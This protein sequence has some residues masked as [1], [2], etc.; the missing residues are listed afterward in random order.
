MARLFASL[1]AIW[2]SALLVA[3]A[4]AQ[5]KAAI[6]NVKQLPTE[7]GNA[8]Y[9]GNREPLAP[10]P[11]VKLPIGA[12]KPGGWLLHQ[13]ELMA[14]GMTGR[15]HEVSPFLRDDNGWVSLKGR[16]WE[17]PPYWLKGY[18]DLGYILGNERII[19]EARRWLE[20]AIASQQPD[21][22]FGPPDNKEK[23]DLWPNMPMLAALQSYYEYSGDKRVL[24]LMGKYFAYESAMPR[25]KLL[26]E[27]WQHVRGGDNLES[28]YWLYNR[29]GDP[30]LLEIAKVIFEKTANWTEKIPTWHGVNLTMGIRQPG[31][32]YQQSKDRKH[33]DAVER[34]YRTVMDEYGQA[35]GGMFGADENARKGFTGPQQAAE[36][37]SMVEFM[38]SNESLLKITGDLTYADRCEDI[39]LNS[40]PASYT[41]DWRG[42]HYLTAPNQTSCDKGGEHCYQN[43]GM[44][45][46]YS[47]GTAYRCCQHNVSHGWPY[48]AEHLWMATAGNGLAAIFYMPST[49]TAK[50]GGA[51]SEVTIH[52]YTKYPFGQSVE[53]V[54]ETKGGDAPWPFVLRVPGWC[55]SA[56]L[57]LNDAKQEIAPPPQSYLIVD[58]AWKNG[59]HVRLEL[60]M[61]ITLATWAKQADAVS[62][63]RGPLT[64]SLKMGEK[65]APFG[66]PKWPNY[67]VLPTT[68]WNFGLLVDRANPER[69]F[70][71]IEHSWI[72]YQPWEANCAPIALRTKA[73]RVPDWKL[74]L[75]EPGPLPQSPVATSEPPEAITLI[76]MGCA[77]LRVSVFPTA[78]PPAE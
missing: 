31:V 11:L 52:E 64:Y 49:V 1:M 35:P 3:P 68:P 4:M 30:K 66:S 18:G 19:K 67:E 13:L 59:D 48:Y 74:V 24:D 14:D 60:P 76:P 62:V 45:V 12:I 5:E 75:N 56:R 8:H 42:L 23:F 47:P 58:R 43:D 55:K 2:L 50:V 73:R 44:M 6:R 22:Y 65:W 10:S 53:F 20:K 63:S 25:E 9:I 16:G 39:A 36:T 28:I 15:L 51:G 38:Y 72:P 34:N 70:E 78:T 46:A 41:P 26:A 27:S 33:L 17:E 7:G 37:C 21:G 57:F 32:Y 61:E 29:T 77:R 40:F 54:I 71:V 69:S